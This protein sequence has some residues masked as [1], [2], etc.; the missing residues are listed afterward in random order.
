MS[1]PTIG[2]CSSLVAAASIP[3]AERDLSHI[4][5]RELQ[6]L[7]VPFFEALSLINEGRDLDAIS[8]TGIWDGIA[9]ALALKRLGDT[10]IPIKTTEQPAR[11]RY[12]HFKETGYFYSAMGPDAC[13]ERVPAD[14]VTQMA[15]NILQIRSGTRPSVAFRSF[16]ENL[17][18]LNHTATIH[19]AA[20]LAIL[21]KY[22]DDNFDKVFAGKQIRVGDKNDPIIATFFKNTFV[23]PK[24]VGEILHLQNHPTYAI[25]HIVGTSHGKNFVCIEVSETDGNPLYIG[26]GFNPS[27]VTLEEATN[28]LLEDYNTPP[29]TPADILSPKHVDHLEATLKYR[30][31]G[32]EA[33]LQKMKIHAPDIL[34]AHRK[35]VLSKEEFLKKSLLPTDIH[36]A[37]LNSDAIQA[38]FL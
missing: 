22:G 20:Y 31:G 18:F 26:L 10:R 1:S 12:N 16:H 4:F 24:K 14:R 2:A 13:W 36:D 34:E 37:E 29:I 21:K 23:G 5:A 30:V 6:Q 35:G 27:G 33:S 8:K 11:M 9:Y 3:D 19:I 15:K 7:V 25:K 28:A 17:S 32:E 38:L